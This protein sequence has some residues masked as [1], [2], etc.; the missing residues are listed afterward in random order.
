MKVRSSVHERAWILRDLVLG[1]DDGMITTFA[2]ISGSAG[3]SLTTGVVVILGL[4]NLFADGLSMAFS[5]YMGTK[6]EVEFEKAKGEPHWRSDYPLK[7]G[8]ITFMSFVIAGLIPLTPYLLNMKGRFWISSFILGISLFF[9]G[10]FKS[11]RTGKNWVRGGAE[12]L[13]TGGAMATVAYLVGFFAERYL[14]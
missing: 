6:S 13:A 11:V 8:F 5:V 2:I 10:V 4:A 3:A 14:V 7:Q 9:I 12:M 1:A